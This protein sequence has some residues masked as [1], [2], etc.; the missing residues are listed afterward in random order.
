[1]RFD[2]F[3]GSVGVYCFL[4]PRTKPIS[5]VVRNILRKVSMI[6][7]LQSLRLWLS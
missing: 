2:G 6:R 7:R 4:H 1:M 5:T 3:F